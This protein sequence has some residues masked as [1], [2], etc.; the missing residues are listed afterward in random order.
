MANPWDPLPFPNQGDT[1][2]NKTFRYVGLVVTAWE[3]VE[4]ELAR[5]HSVL[6]EDPD[7]A[8]LQELYGAG[9]IFRD[10]LSALRREF[11]RYRVSLCCQYREGEF[12]YLTAA[13]EGFSNRRHEV[14]HGLVIRADRLTYIRQKLESWH[15][16]K[17][18]F[19]LLPPLY[20]VRWHDGGLPIYAYSS[21]ELNELTARLLELSKRIGDFR[22]E[23][24]G[25]RKAPP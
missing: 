14:A 4:F 13:A 12:D 22:T 18:Q 19:L 24:L 6:V 25:L 9:N 8:S 21:V 3:S 17:P 23:C 7:G 5:L 11:D 20:T 16:D 15:G 1:R 2:I 10:R